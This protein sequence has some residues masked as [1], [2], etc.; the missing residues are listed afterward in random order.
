MKGRH[1][2]AGAIY[3]AGIIFFNGQVR[4][5]CTHGNCKHGWDSKYNESEQVIAKLWMF[6]FPISIFLFYGLS[7]KKDEEIPKEKNSV[8]LGGGTQNKVEDEENTNLPIKTN[9]EIWIGI[10]ED[11]DIV[12]YSPIIQYTEDGNSV[13]LWCY[14]DKKTKVYFK[15]LAKAKLR[16]YTEHHKRENIISCFV[17]FLKEYPY[18]K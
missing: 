18:K 6:G 13:V 15:P 1:I 10:F 14:S 12:V 2:V 7:S 11:G 4:D 3:I 8:T 16:K 17:E 9:N 5:A